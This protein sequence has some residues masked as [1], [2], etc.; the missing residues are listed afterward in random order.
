MGK[1]QSYRLCMFP[2]SLF[3]CQTYFHGPNKLYTNGIYSSLKG[4]KVPTVARHGTAHKTHGT[5][6]DL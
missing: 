6:G 3:N 1:K 4:I 2:N 5:H